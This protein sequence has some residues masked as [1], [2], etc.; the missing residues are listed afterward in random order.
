[1]KKKNQGAIHI[2]WLASISGVTGIQIDLE[3]SQPIPANVII[4]IGWS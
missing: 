3:E 2:A 1:M 4:D